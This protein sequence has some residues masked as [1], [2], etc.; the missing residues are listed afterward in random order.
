MGAH[1]ETV[2]HL[3]MTA[4]SR[5]TRCSIVGCKRDMGDLREYLASTWYFHITGYVAHFQNVWD[6]LDDARKNQTDWQIR[7]ENLLDLVNHQHLFLGSRLPREWH[8]LNWGD[9]YSGGDFRNRTVTSRHVAYEQGTPS[10]IIRT[11]PNTRTVTRY[12]QH[13]GLCSNPCGVCLEFCDRSLLHGTRRFRYHRLQEKLL[14]RQ[15]SHILIG[16]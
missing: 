2:K 5:Y 13:N 15:H 3:V 10:I 8:F 4:K 14:D 11:N 1:D 6:F 12:H 7:W 16:N 9:S